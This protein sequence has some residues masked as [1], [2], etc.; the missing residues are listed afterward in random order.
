MGDTPAES[1]APAGPPFQCVYISFTA[2]VSEATVE[3]LL[4]LCGQIATQGILQVCLMLST[5]GGSVAHGIT[6]YN[7]L[8]ALPFRLVTHNTGNVNSIGNVLFLAGEDRYC[9]PNATFMFHGVSWNLPGASSLE[10]RH[11]RELLA[12]VTREQGRIAEI[13]S[14]RTNIRSHE[15]KKLF[16]VA[17]TRNAEYAKASGI[18]HDVRELKIPPGA[19]VHQVVFQR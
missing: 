8:R 2:E 1:A 19:P 5:P 16:R 12:N 18:V 9:S 3:A 17:E 7:T 6:A 15:I 11:L 14:A 10:E 4:G 13:V